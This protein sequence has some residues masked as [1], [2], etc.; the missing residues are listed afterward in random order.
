MTDQPH[1]DAPQ[2]QPADATTAEG[3]EESELDRLRRDVAE[4]DA[5]IEQLQRMAAEV[6]NRRKRAERQADDRVRFALQD[7]AIDLLPVIDNFERALDHAGDAGSIQGLHDGL[8]LVH[9]QL[10]GVLGKYEVVKVAALGNAFDPNE[11]EAVGQM[12]SADHPDQTVIE[13][14]QNGYRLHDRVIRPSR[15]LVSRRP[16]KDAPGESRPDDSAD[17][18]EGEEDA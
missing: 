2:E 16:Q 1:D 13:V 6:D 15:V 17:E 10:L 9:D 3:A 4:R 8:Q 14:H 5:K 7:L 12:I 11:H 18:G